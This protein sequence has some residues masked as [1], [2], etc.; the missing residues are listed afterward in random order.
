M[1]QIDNLDSLRIPKLTIQPI[2]ENAIQHSLEEIIGECQIHITFKMSEDHLYITVQD[3]GV[4]MT[5]ETI[6]SIYAGT[7]KPKRSGIGLA[8]IMERLRIMFGEPYGI[9]IES[10]VGEGTAVIVKIPSAKE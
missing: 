5:Q 9:Q 6:D 1:E 2:V 10:R 7:V 4:G 3:N 8:N